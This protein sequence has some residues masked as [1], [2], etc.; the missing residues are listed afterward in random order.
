[1]ASPP[2]PITTSP[3]TE[4]QLRSVL[5][6]LEKNQTVLIADLGDLE[7]RILRTGTAD[8]AVAQ[9]DVL[10]ASSAGGVSPA[11]ATSANAARAVG[12]ALNGAA[13]GGNVV[14][15]TLGVLLTFSGL[16]VAA[17]Y[18]LS[19]VTPGAITPTAPTTTGQYVV[20]VGK[21]LTTTDFLFSPLIS[22]LL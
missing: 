20:P 7:D 10:Y 5:N 18:Y 8:A 21:S 6:R 12:V 11:I 13:I 17:T 14:Y 9:N 1:M 15:L 22:V 4:S 2:R 19:A 16:V 3:K